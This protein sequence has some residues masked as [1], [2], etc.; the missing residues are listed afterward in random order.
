MKNVQD[1]KKL[2]V[3]FFIDTVPGELNN[4][5]EAPNYNKKIVSSFLEG[6]CVWSQN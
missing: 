6:K 2:S 3:Q 4:Q 1:A 5:P